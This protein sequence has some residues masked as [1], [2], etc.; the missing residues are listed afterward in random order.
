MFPIKQA[1]LIIA[2]NEFAVLQRLVSMLDTS[3]SDFYI[4]F[5]KKV[6]KIPQV[7]VKHGQ[8][9]ILE[10]KIDVRW[11]TV[12]QIEVELLLLRTAIE[13]GPYEHYHILSGTHLPLVSVSE[14]LDF[15]NANHGKEIVRFWPED[16]GDADFKLRRYHFPIKNFKNGHPLRRHLC[17]LI[18]RVVVRFQKILGIRHYKRDVFRKT[19]QWLSLTERSAKYLAANRSR[20]LRKYRFSLCGD[21]Y[22]VASELLTSGLGFVLQ[23]V[24]NLLYVRF[25]KESP[26]SISLDFYS[27]LKEFGFIW[28]RKF[29][30]NNVDRLG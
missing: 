7:V 21:E 3:E 2:H 13:H 20:I 26:E 24:P 17:Q 30:T 29:T 6:K 27:E 18:W 22:F 5:D 15:Y 25:I 28:G 9:I 10:H 1:W 4:H 19:D 23:D 16:P 8:L 11:G 14:L 12:S